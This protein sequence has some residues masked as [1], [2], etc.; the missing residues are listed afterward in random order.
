VREVDLLAHHRLAL[1][2]PRTFGLA[3]DLQDDPP[4]LV[5][6]GREVD[7]PAVPPHVRDE[8]LE[9]VVEVVQ[10]VLLDLAGQLAEL[11]RLGQF[12]HPE[13]PGRVLAEDGVVDR[14]LELFVP[15]RGDAGRVEVERR[16]GRQDGRRSSDGRGLGVR[17]GSGHGRDCIS[18]AGRAFQLGA[19]LPS[20]R[21]AFE[22]WRLAARSHAE[23]LL[24]SSR[25]PSGGDSRPGVRDVLLAR[26]AAG[27]LLLIRR[28]L[29]AS[30]ACPTPSSA[31]TLGRLAVPGRV[32]RTWSATLLAPT[33][34][35]LLASSSALVVAALLLV[36]VASSCD[37]RALHWPCGRPCRSL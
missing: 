8:L 1:D 16:L 37:L 35:A 4:G 7:V 18:R 36:L 31:G 20:L 6:V 34:E 17:R 19:D 30:T 13:L 22:R 15:G 3:G 25:S 26:A 23:P 2:H 28:L 9:V 27:P 24:L 33:F 12:Q 29:S 14:R 5:G 11:V 32:R 21:T 10:R